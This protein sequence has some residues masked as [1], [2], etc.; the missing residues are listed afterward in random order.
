M[1]L[2]TCTER[3]VLRILVFCN[4]RYFFVFVTAVCDLLLLKLKRQK[5]KCVYET[6]LRPRISNIGVRVGGGGGGGVQGGCS[7]PTPNFGQL[8]FFGAARE[9]L[10]KASF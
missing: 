3:Q 7:S 1:L 2:H 5:S 8:R 9:N 10:G 4:V 6:Y